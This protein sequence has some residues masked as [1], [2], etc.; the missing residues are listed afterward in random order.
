MN[1]SEYAFLVVVYVKK[2]LEM[3]GV[4]DIFSPTKKKAL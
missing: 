1:I 2:D 3:A 4:Y